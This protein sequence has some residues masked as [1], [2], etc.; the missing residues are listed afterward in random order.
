MSVHAT[1]DPFLSDL[2]GALPA[3]GIWPP[4]LVVAVSGGADSMALLLG[5]A[6]LAAPEPAKRIVV[7]HAEHDLRPEAPADRDFV[8]AVAR[9]LGLPFISRPVAARVHDGVRGEG[10]EARARR[11]RYRF[12]ADVAHECG[13]RYVAVAHTADD[14]AETVLHRALRGTGLVG[15]AAMAAARPCGD[16]V[17]LV[18][19]LLTMPR[20]VVRSWLAARGH[21]WIDDATNADTRHARNFL[22]HEI[23]ARCQA[24]PYP[25]AAAALV[26]LAEHASRTSA[27]LVSAADHFLDSHAICRAGG[28]VIIQAAACDRLDPHFVAEVAAA[29]WRREGWPQRDMTARH[30]RSFAALIAAVAAEGRAPAQDFPGGIHAESGPGRTLVVGRG[31]DESSTRR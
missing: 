26:R 23:L 16:G 12:L 4:G 20:A 27:A 13:A 28:G 18:R 17:A 1:V 29:L 14:Q 22:R 30:F 31:H 6:A 8:A 7:A 10:L 24:G 2:R 9:D 3:T 15:L 21:R 19:P 25:A 5:L 11:L